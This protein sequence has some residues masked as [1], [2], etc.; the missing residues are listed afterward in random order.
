MLAVNVIAVEADDE[1]GVGVAEVP[2]HVD[3]LGV[4][5]VVE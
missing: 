5:L 2:A 3:P 4:K 1:L